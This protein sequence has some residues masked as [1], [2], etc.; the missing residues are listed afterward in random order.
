MSCRQCAWAPLCK[1]DVSVC[2]GFT[3]NSCNRSK[4]NSDSPQ[5]EEEWCQFKL[6]HKKEILRMKSMTKSSRKHKNHRQTSGPPFKTNTIPDPLDSVVPLLPE[7]NNLFNQG[8]VTT[9]DNSDDHTP[10]MSHNYIFPIPGKLVCY[11]GDCA[12]VNVC[13]ALSFLSCS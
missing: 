8:V 6:A 13:I 2:N 5:N 4:I 10:S 3:W 1:C 9:M 12:D 11:S 7:G